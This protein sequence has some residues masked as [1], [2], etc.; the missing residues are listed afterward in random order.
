MHRFINVNLA[1]KSGWR[2]GVEL[3]GWVHVGLFLCTLFG[4]QPP[5]MDYWFSPTYYG[6]SLHKLASQAID[7][8]RQP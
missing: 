3:I 4:F 6:R 5:G 7:G 8:E 2:L 1:T